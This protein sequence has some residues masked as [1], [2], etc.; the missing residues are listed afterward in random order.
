K[1]IF[2]FFFSKLV[3]LTYSCS[4][5]QQEISAY[6]GGLSATATTTTSGGAAPSM[7]LNQYYSAQSVLKMQKIKVVQTGYTEYFEV[8]NFTG[9]YSGLQHTPDSAS[10]GGTTSKTLIA[11]LW[12]PNTDGGIHAMASYIGQGTIY[13]RFGGEGDGAK[14]INP[15]GWKVG[16]WYNVAHR[17][18]KSGDSAFVANYIQDVASGAWFLTSV[19]SMPS[20]S[21]LLSNYDDS[22]LEN[23]NGSSPSNDGST[24][25]KALFKDCWALN[26]SGDWMKPN[27]RYV[28]INTSAADSARNGIYNNNFDAGYN[29]A[30]DAFY[31]AHGAGVVPSAIFNGTRSATLPNQTNQG[32]VPSLGTVSISSVSASNTNGVTTI[33]WT[34]PT[35]SAPQFSTNIEIVNSSNTVVASYVDTVPQ[36]RSAN[37]TTLLAPGSYSA[38][39]TVRDIFNRQSTSVTNTFFVASSGIISNAIYTLQ[40]ACALGRSLDVDYSGISDGSNVSIYST[41]EN[42][43]Q[44]WKI[45]DIGGGYYKL[46]S[47]N[48]LSKALDVS[49]GGTTSGTNV[50]IYSDNGSN[51]QKWKITNLGNGYFKLQPANAP[52]LCLDAYSGTDANENVQIYTDHGGN[53]QRWK[54]TFVSN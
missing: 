25:R 6:K 21:A 23:W 4:K 18:W 15:Y 50:Q 11:S 46:L 3:G 22:F 34:V 30:E 9:G 13:S 28:S 42:P 52:T 1:K 40:P 51:A 20:S 32:S 7:H 2:F 44:K 17:G 47:V 31:M 5:T 14:T 37:L 19:L 36:R 48:I 8:N 27:S 54:L 26:V 43:N 49:N 24:P 10:S 35:T 16:S 41:T 38:R 33:N 53:S 39:V 29:S 45:V 12:D